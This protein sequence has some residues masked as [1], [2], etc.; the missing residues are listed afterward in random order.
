MITNK[1]TLQD[2]INSTYTVWCLRSLS[3]V[4][5]V[6]LRGLSFITG[7]GLLLLQETDELSLGAACSSSIISSSFE[8]SDF[9]EK[10]GKGS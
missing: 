2:E 10:Q 8:P 4:Y 5:L 6:G 9:W 3:T 1:K 7:E